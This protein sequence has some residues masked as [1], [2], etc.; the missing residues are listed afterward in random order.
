MPLQP[1]RPQFVF[2]RMTSVVK[3]LLFALLGCYVLQL[4]LE[5]W[6]GIPVV[7]LLALT[8]GGIGL[9]QLLT[10]VLVDVG[11]PMMFL[12]GLL[13]I[14]WALSPFE[15]SFGR[16][17]TI[18]LCLV[19]TLA[20]ALPVYLLGFFLAGSP[21]LF[22]S[23]VLWFGGISAYSWSHRNS[24]MSLFGMATMTAKQFLLLMV[25]L[26]FLM[27]LA[28]KNHSHFIAS[29]GAMAGGIG[30]IRW[31]SRPRSG[32]RIRKRAPRGGFRV[33]DGGAGRDSE[34][35]KYLN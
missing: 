33:I 35:P 7:G 31:M 5:G 4:V 9:W 34:R 22:G 25:G 29:L 18:Q 32:P 26:S 23:S 3:T 10:Y 1:S 15:L 16:R 28:S 14:W 12:L 21:P 13:F 17:A 27:F 20:G 24:V 19:A 2:P 30:Y 11:H 8:P 6:L